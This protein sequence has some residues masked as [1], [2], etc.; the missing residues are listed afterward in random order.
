MAGYTDINDPSEHFQV[1]KYTASGGSSHAI[2]CDGNS[3]MGTDWFWAKKISGGGDWI[4]VDSN[5]GVNTINYWGASRG[6]DTNSVYHTSFDSDGVT[7]GG[8]LAGGDRY[9]EITVAN[10][11][12]S[13]LSLIHI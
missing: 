2:V 7:T 1:K 5:R 6:V 10:N 4:G 8:S 13:T 3:D 11:A 9:L 12:P